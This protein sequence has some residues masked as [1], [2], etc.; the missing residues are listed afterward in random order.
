MV[1]VAQISDLHLVEPAHRAR[2]G[3]HALR[4]RFLSAHR[5]I[6]AED[7]LARARRALAVAKASAADHYVLTGDLTEDG[8]VTQF[9]ML[10]ELLGESGLAPSTVTLVPGNHDV[11]DHAEGWSRALAGPLRAYAATSRAGEEVVVGDLAVVPVD[12]SVHQH[13]VFSSGRLA[14]GLAER[15]DAAVARSRRAGRA[16]ALVQHHP[17]M[18]YA[19]PLVQWVDGMHGHRRTRTVLHDEAHV[20][21]VH[22]H[23][24]RAADRAVSLGRGAQVFSAPAVVDGDDPV[25]V[26]VV[27]G[28]ALRGA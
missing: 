19:M 13:W 2:R 9:E 7:R 24:H 6:D 5:P 8:T 22:G 25:R 11:I 26:Y 10:A 1:R 15:V 20:H 18:P 27:E 16:V 12:T 14:P 28:G 21:V 17:V 4:L 3:V 23:V